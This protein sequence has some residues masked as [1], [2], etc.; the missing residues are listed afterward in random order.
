MKKGRTPLK[1]I[2]AKCLDC[3]NGDAEEV[4]Q[5]PVRTCPLWPLRMGRGYQDPSKP[6]ISAGA[7]LNSI[8]TLEPEIPMLETPCFAGIGENDH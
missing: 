1:V 4:K 5:C 7:E 2:R 6:A 8:V 3:S